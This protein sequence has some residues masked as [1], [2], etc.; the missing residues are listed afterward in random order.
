MG[1]TLFWI[2][3][4]SLASE[5]LFCCSPGGFRGTSEFGDRLFR[6]NL[7]EHG[8]FFSPCPPTYNLKENWTSINAWFFADTPSKHE[9]YLIGSI[10]IEWH[11]I[12][13]ITI[14]N[15]FHNNNNGN[16][17]NTL[18]NDNNNAYW[19]IASSALIPWSSS[20]FLQ[21]EVDFEPVSA[22]VAGKCHGQRRNYCS[23]RAIFVE[24]E[25]AWS[26]VLRFPKRSC[27]PDWFEAV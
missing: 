8:G 11:V 15:N 26:S 22:H 18:Y 2:C 19:H 20:D 4:T 6:W 16:N 1:T 14:C 7:S 10:S 5:V 9:R 12:V 23:G 13:N 27:G 17:N 25:G 3:W 21:A 24:A